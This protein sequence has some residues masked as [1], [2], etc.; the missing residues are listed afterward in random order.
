MRYEHRFR[1]A[2]PVAA[3][4]EFHSRAASMAAI[5]PPPLIVRVH[6]APARLGEGDEME[7]TMWAGPLPLRWVARIE[8]VSPE[9]FTDRQ[10]RGPFR[11]WR[12]HHAFVQRAD[13]VT[14][15]VD[16]VDA[17]LRRHV[18]WGPV[19]LAMWIG[20]PV[21]FVYRGWKTRRLLERQG[22]TR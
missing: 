22:A 20:L 21:L 9:G 8:D 3:V 2:A 16:R 1:V 6:R 7:F 12:H 4:A 10:L 13:D 11:E 14:E 18:L 17:S 19:G 5:T 15:V